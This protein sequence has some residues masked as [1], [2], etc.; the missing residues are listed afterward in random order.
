MRQEIHKID[1]TKNTMINTIRQIQSTGMRQEIHEINTT[2]NT[3]SNTIRQIQSTKQ[4]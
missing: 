3:M 4:E 1:T 2:K